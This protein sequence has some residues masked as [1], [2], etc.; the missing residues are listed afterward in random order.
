V[1]A[2]AAIA[3][4][5]DYHPELLTAVM[6]INRDQRT[7]IVDKLE[8]CL[9]GIAERTVGLLGLAF[10]PNTDDIREAPSIEI[11]R[12]LL[13]RGARVRACDPAAVERARGILP[14]IKYLRDAYE[15]AD[16]ADALIVVTEWNEFRHLDLA[17]IKRSMRGPVLID[18]RNIYDPTEMRG[19]G[20]VY[21][22]VGRN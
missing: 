1:K 22:G 7:L 4:R 19:L 16:G 2:L 5:Y 3:E 14:Q 12:M 20:F 6:A 8:E 15:V 21:R 11:A 13:D 10:K 17:R 18:G 9:G